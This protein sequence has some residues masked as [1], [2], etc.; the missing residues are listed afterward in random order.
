VDRLAGLASLWGTGKGNKMALVTEVRY[1]VPVSGNIGSRGRFPITQRMGRA[2]VLV[3]LLRRVLLLVMGKHDIENRQ[4]GTDQSDTS[5][6]ITTR[7]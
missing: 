5:L 4:T 7:R 6:G 2:A 1:L 3:V